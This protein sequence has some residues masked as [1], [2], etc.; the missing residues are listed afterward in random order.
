ML[1]FRIVE[2]IIQTAP[3]NIGTKGRSKILSVIVI[4]DRP[5]SVPKDG[6]FEIITSSYPAPIFPGSSG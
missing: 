3:V 4:A 1:S 5:N 6:R 2:D